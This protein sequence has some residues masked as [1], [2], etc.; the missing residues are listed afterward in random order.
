MNVDTLDW[1]LLAARLGVFFALVLLIIQLDSYMDLMQPLV[2]Q[3][4]MESVP[5]DREGDFSADGV[6]AI[7]I[8]SASEVIA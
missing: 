6:V 8:G 7:R 2:D 5:R 4:R 3:C 1:L